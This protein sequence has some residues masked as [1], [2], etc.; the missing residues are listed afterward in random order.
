MLRGAVALSLAICIQAAD[1]VR[2]ERWQQDL[3]FL[4][5]ELPQRHVNWYAAVERARFEAAVA[6][7][8]RAIPELSDADVIVG[9]VRIVALGRD[10]HTSIVLP[11]NAAPFRPVGLQFYWFPEGLFVTAASP[12]LSRALGAR[13]I[14]IADVEVERAYQAVA[15]VI[16][17][18]NDYWT[19]EMSQ[20]Y[21][22][23]PEVLRALRLAPDAAT[24]RYTFEDA[25]GERFALEAAPQGVSLPLPT[26]GDGFT[27][28]YRRNTSANYWFEHLENART[29]YFKY[30]LAREMTSQSFADFTRQIFAVMDNNPVERLVFDVRNNPGG[31]SAVIEPFFQGM[32]ERIARMQAFVLTN[33]GTTSSGMRAA[34]AGQGTPN[35][36][37]LGEPTGGKPN[38]FGDRREFS[39]PNSELVVGYSIQRFTVSGQ[40]GDAL[41]PDLSVPLSA[42]DYFARHDPLQVPGARR[43]QDPGR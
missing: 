31:N 12:D 41:F 11:Q 18:E 19:R 43:R 20:R 2:D 35:V 29:L 14:R 37:L 32:V 21:L 25:R 33:R 13:V 27:P 3:R 5:A 40:E 23:L 1:P 38:A 7:L 22:A 4:A 42:A 10:A 39:L 9:M 17:A 24:V 15:T 30:N 36:L 6:E 8:D 28:L 34:L 26:P 16:S